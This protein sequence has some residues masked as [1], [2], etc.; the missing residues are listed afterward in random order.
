MASVRWSDGGQVE[1]A[2][3]SKNSRDRD[4]VIAQRP[5]KRLRL[6]PKIPL[7][8]R[9][10]NKM[11]FPATAGLGVSPK[12][13]GIGSPR[14]WCNSPAHA[15]QTV[16]FGTRATLLPA[17][18]ARGEPQSVVR[19]GY[20]SRSRAWELGAPAPEQADV[21]YPP[22]RPYWRLGTG[23][24]LKMHTIDF[25][26]GGIRPTRTNAS[27]FAPAS[28]ISAPSVFIEKNLM[29]PPSQSAVK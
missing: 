5:M 26:K 12:V 10:S 2:V 15:L 8:S 13:K 18:R 3:I 17:T 21:S 14:N 25:A 9:D 27:S 4:T 23:Y 19:Q 16:R 22:I 24:F 29:C 7:G 1:Q 6:A 20:Q 11:F 28:R